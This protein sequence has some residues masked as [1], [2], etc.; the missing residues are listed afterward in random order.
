[1]ERS[2]KEKIIIIWILHPGQSQGSR[3]SEHDKNT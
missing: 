3:Q 2:G 1:V